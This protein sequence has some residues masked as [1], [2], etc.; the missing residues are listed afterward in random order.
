MNLVKKNQKL[1]DPDSPLLVGEVRDGD[2]VKE[3]DE[4]SYIDMQQKLI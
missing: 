1:H 2:V 4:P 3:V